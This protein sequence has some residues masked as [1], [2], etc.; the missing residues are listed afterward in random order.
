ML[1]SELQFNLLTLHIYFLESNK[2][3]VESLKYVTFYGTNIL[4]VE[5]F[6]NF[7]LGIFTI[8]NYYMLIWTSEYNM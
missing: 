1:Y 4:K 6:R 8:M 3:V 2:V 7:F 5:N